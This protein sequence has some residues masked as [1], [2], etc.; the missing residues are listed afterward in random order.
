MQL[1]PMYLYVNCIRKIM[2][3]GI[4]PTV[5]QLLACIVI[6]ILAMVI[7]MSYFYKKQKLFILHI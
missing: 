2:L 3:Y 5:F 4:T 7:G 1:N 6:G